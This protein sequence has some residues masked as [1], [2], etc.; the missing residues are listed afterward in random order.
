MLWLA[1]E[2]LA[3]VMSAESEG[4]K[5]PFE[6]DLQVMAAAAPVAGA[7]VGR[8][9]ASPAPNSALKS[10]GM[11]RVSGSS[12]EETEK[13]LSKL[14]EYVESKGGHNAAVHKHSASLCEAAHAFLLRE[15]SARPSQMY[16]VPLVIG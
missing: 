15:R 2:T 6:H 4:H 12:I 16:W 10:G 14:R 9:S 7:P 3:L 8:L 11:A 5:D 13:L 1:I